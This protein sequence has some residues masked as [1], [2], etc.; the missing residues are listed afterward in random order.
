MYPGA[1]VLL[2]ITLSQNSARKIFTGGG[3][4]IRIFADFNGVVPNEFL[5]FFRRTPGVI[6]QAGIVGRESQ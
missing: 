3:N 1:G 2:Q 5:K 4:P 6:W